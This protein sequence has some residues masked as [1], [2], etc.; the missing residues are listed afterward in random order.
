MTRKPRHGAK[1]VPHDANEDATG[2]KVAAA[3]NLAEPVPVAARSGPMPDAHAAEQANHELIAGANLT[4]SAAAGEIAEHEFSAAESLSEPPVIGMQAERMAATAG[5]AEPARAG[6]LT[7][8]NV[9]VTTSLTEPA[10][11]GKLK[12]LLVSLF[13]PELVRGGAQQVCYELFQALQ[14]RDDLDVTLLASI[15]QGL[16]ALYKSGARITGFDGRRNEFLFLSRDYDHVW[17]KMTN[18]LL[19]E[20]FAEFLEQIQPDVIHFHHF[21]TYGID[22]LSLT[23]RVLPH[24]RLVFTF[25]EFLSICHS[26]G[27]M[28]RTTD[29][30]LCDHASPVRCHQCFPEWAPEH[31]FVRRLWMLQHFSVIDVFTTPSRFM[32]SR[33]TDWGIDPARIVCV[34]NGQQDYSHGHAVTETRRP[35]RNRFGFFGQL[36]DNKGAWLLLRAVEL[37]RAE[38]FTDFTVELNGGNTQYASE[39][40]R[41][42]LHAF[43]AKEEAR[44][45]DEQI[46]LFNGAYHTDELSRLMAQV[47]WCIVP[48][49][50]WETFGLVISEAWM[51]R[52]P[53]IVSDVGAMAERVRDGVDGLHFARGSARSLAE[54]MLRACTETDLWDQLAGGIEVPSGR[55]TMAQRFMEI[56][57]GDTVEGLGQAADQGSDS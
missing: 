56:Y 25:H 35:K 40:R 21:L 15:D 22:M 36:V 4:W 43:Q 50:W 45:T 16:P 5:L 42:E 9:A 10:R 31:F 14:E 54:T 38:G 20:S 49:V 53:V 52:R 24:C 34:P 47:D 19:T 17:H 28:L 18:P 7:E 13:H 33:F 41:A 2:Q 51:F 12:V 48:S 8:Q 57:Q 32:M 39:P 11:S 30:S 46:V 26:H 3:A 37:L 55:D 23:R 29:G 27:H 6:R 44:P 1:P